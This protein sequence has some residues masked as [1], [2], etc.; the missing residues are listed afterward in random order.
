MELT[1]KEIKKLNNHCGGADYCSVYTTQEAIIACHARQPEDWNGKCPYA[2]G[3]RL[4]KMN[5]NELVPI[6][7]E[8]CSCQMTP[9]EYI[10]WN[11]LCGRQQG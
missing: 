7:C 3:T 4:P 6:Q 2:D 1:A 5:S 11:G 10:S 9:A 8:D